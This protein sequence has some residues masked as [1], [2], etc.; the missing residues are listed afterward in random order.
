MARSSRSNG[1]ETNGITGKNDSQVR[2]V[3][4]KLRRNGMV[5]YRYGVDA[6]YTR[7]KLL[8]IAV[9]NHLT[10]T[11]VDGD[12]E[13]IIIDNAGRKRFTYGSK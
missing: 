3:L 11:D 12:K 6:D 13:L 10:V 2:R 4:A 7:G 8:D 5:I 1:Y 9:N